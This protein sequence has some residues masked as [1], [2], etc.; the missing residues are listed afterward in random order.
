MES[1]PK[2][3]MKLP[4]R[5]M[6][7][8]VVPIGVCFYCCCVSFVCVVAAGFP[9][10]LV[11]QMLGLHVNTV[12]PP[13]YVVPIGIATMIYYRLRQCRRPCLS[14]AVLSIQHRFR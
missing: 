6:A 13:M 9:V 8:G 3:V 1:G 14:R 5:V 10:I 11:P 12:W 7:G 4:G 2:G